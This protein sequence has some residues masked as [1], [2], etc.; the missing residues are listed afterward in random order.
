MSRKA[1]VLEVAG[2]G[3]WREAEARVMVEAWR[4]SGEALSEFAHRHRVAPKRIARWASRV[5]RPGPAVRFHPV[6]LA[7]ERSESGSSS[8]I[9]IQLLGGRR[10]RVARGFE[11]EDLRRVLAVL[12]E[13]ARC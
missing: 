2:R 8:A 6:R 9:E 10:V 7:D 13:K 12:E 11:A 1:H 3:Y 4:S 5:G